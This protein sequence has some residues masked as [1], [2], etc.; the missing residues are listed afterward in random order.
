METSVPGPSP[1]QIIEKKKHNIELTYSEIKW[2]ID[3]YLKEETQDCQMAA[4]LMASSLNGMTPSEVAFLTKAMLNS[5]RILSFK[6]SHVVDKHSTGGIGD[7]TSF[8]VAPIAAVAGVKVPMIAGRGLGHTGGTIDKLE[9]LPGYNT[10]L[11]LNE[12]QKLVEKNGAAIIGQTSEIAPS[13]QQVYGLRDITATVD[14]IP[15]VTASIMSKKLAEGLNGLVLDVKY[16]EGSFFPAAKAAREL[17]ISLGEAAHHHGVK[18]MAFITD[19]S[20]PLGQAVGNGIE[21]MEAMEVLKGSGPRDL[22]SLSLN[23]AAGMIF[24]GGKA[25]NLQEAKTMAKQSIADGSAFK[26]FMQMLE[27]Q[28]AHAE[29]LRQPDLLLKSTL[30]T[31]VM[32]AQSGYITHFK[33]KQIGMR[34]ID[35]GG[36]RKVKGQTIDHQVGFFFHRKLGDWVEEGE[37]L[38]TIFHREFQV[39]Q[40]ANLVSEFRNEI[41]TISD[42]PAADIPLIYDRLTW[43]N[44]EVKP[45]I[46]N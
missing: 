36:G 33:N 9:S 30:K 17:A 22:T 13:D 18:C 14:S 42:G 15:L 19:M 29:Y 25:N 21:V 7:K 39:T 40:I 8:I 3:S 16:G 31:E 43:P 11:P 37:S 44:E 41:I 26:K 10:C 32:A 34:L 2:L 27:A 24:L 23:L 46:K 38:L 6:D 28:G 5:G 20:Q 12:F 1:Y 45:C 4:F 35:L